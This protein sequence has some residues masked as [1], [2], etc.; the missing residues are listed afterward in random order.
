MRPTLGHAQT[1]A[2]LAVLLAIRQRAAARC[3]SLRAAVQHTR[4]RSQQLRAKALSFIIASIACAR[5]ALHAAGGVGSWRRCVQRASC[6]WRGSTLAGYLDH[7]D[8]ITFKENFRCTRETFERLCALLKSAAGLAT[9]NGTVARHSAGKEVRFKKHSSEHASHI[10]A[11]KDIPTLRFKV[12]ACLYSMAYGGHVKVAADVASLGEATLRRYLIRFCEGVCKW[13]KPVYM[14]GT[15]P[16]EERLAAVRGQFASRRGISCAALA[17]DGTHIP[18]KPPNKKVSLDYR[19]Y[20]GW[21]SLL[22]LAFVDSYYMFV[23]LDVGYPGR[24]GD[25]TVLR[26]NW[27]HAAICAAPEKWLG[28]GGV[29]LGDSGASD[30]DGFFLNPYHN[31]TDPESCW[32]NFCHSSTRFFV[33][34]TFGPWKNRFRFLMNHMST[35]HKLTCQL[36][37]AAAVLHNMFTVH[38]SDGLEMTV[39]SCPEWSRFF[40]KYQAHLCP[41]DVQVA[42]C[43]PLRAS[44]QL[45]HG[46]CSGRCST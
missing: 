17:C 29:V 43:G 25:N 46:T 38:A 11:H 28:K 22:A 45:P 23:D 15:P 41:S 10:R 44:S 42:T 37:F 34:E 6:K 8:D 21:T 27:L 26:S 13:V 5:R 16:S 3:R 2:R 32:F 33:E 9:D 12:A 1:R 20:K 14:P 36:I 19:N 31:P 39:G 24:A 35:K 7:G 40:T 18:F 4:Q 30:A